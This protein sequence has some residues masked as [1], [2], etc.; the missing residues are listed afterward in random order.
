MASLCKTHLLACR[1][2]PATVNYPNLSGR[3]AIKDML[4]SD[5]V[6][7]VHLMERTP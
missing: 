2:G 7:V 3:K 6:A 1:A 4:L 5:G